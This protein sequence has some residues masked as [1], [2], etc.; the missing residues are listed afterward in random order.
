MKTIEQ[1]ADELLREDAHRQHKSMRQLGI[2]DDRRAR[3]IREREVDFTDF[4][5]RRR[6][7]RNDEV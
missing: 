2:I 7:Y 4:F 1:A 5:D 6:R 3:T